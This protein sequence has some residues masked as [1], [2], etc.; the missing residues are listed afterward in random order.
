MPCL[1]MSRCL[2][3]DAVDEPRA[4]LYHER[5]EGPVVRSA[6]HF[7]RRSLSILFSGGKG[8]DS[9]VGHK[10][11]CAMKSRVTSLT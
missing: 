5:Y 4:P 3:V 1:G 6:L 7:W 9:D 8:P 11:Y 2:G 10:D